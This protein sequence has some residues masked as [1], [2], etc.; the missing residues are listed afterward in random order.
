MNTPATLNPSRHSSGARAKLAHLALGSL[1]A[2]ALAALAACGGGGS[3]EPEA[4]PVVVPPN[5]KPTVALTAPAA[6]ATVSWGKAVT[7]TATAADSDGTVA[8][9]EFYD[10]DNKSGEIGR[11]PYRV[12]G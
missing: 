4:P 1:T 9:V 5:Q 2:A 7:I 3:S 8:R 6:S 10:G 12:S 11:A